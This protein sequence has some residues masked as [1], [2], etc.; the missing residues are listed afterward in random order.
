MIELPEGASVAGNPDDFLLVNFSIPTDTNLFFHDGDAVGY[1]Q[2]DD[3]RAK[4]WTIR[5]SSYPAYRLQVS[6]YTMTFDTNSDS[7]EVRNDRQPL[8]H[9]IYGKQLYD[10]LICCAT[11][12]V[13]P[14]VLLLSLKQ[15]KPRE[16]G[17]LRN[18]LSFV[19]LA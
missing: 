18:R 11:G 19:M 12:S 9:V 13:R 4:I 6:N 17:W 3:L 16:F 5:N 8:I 10:T 14:K 2:P 7:V 15:R 1:Y